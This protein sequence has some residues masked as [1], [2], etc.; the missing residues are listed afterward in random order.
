MQ[1]ILFFSDT[2]LSPAEPERTVFLADFMEN[3]SKNTAFYILGDLFDIWIGPGHIKLMEYQ[4]I[5]NRLKILTSAGMDINF[6]PGNRDYM[7]GPELTEATGV[8][9]LP[10]MFELNA[11]GKK[12][13]LTHGDLLCTH[14]RDYQRYRRVVQSG[15]VKTI[16]R[17]LPHSMGRTIGRGLKKISARSKGTKTSASKDIV[18]DTVKEYLDQSFDA[19]ICGHIHKAQHIEVLSSGKIKHLF[20]TGAL[21]PDGKG[22]FDLPCVSLIKGKL[23]L[24]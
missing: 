9:V 4:H 24:L 6:I 8:R 7:V 18:M 20:V 2:H 23:E 16:T 14:D 3:Q 12:L 1:R 13:L 5:L 10:E 21:A 11:N 17:N 22:G 19:I 15:V